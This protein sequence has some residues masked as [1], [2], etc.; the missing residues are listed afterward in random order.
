MES[1][2]KCFSVSVSPHPH[3]HVVLGII[4]ILVNRKCYFIVKESDTTELLH[5]FATPWTV[6][7]EGLPMDGF[8]CD[9]DFNFLKNYSI[10]LCT[11]F[12]LEECLF[13]FSAHFYL[14]SASFYFTFV[15]GFLKIYN[16]HII[17]SSVMIFR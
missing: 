14:S 16:L 8:H 7:H 2:Q 11:L 13:R 17:P 12:S 1:Q 3:Q 4:V 6:A 15:P 5:F 9:V 10:V